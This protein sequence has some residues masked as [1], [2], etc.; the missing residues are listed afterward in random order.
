M[1]R[2]YKI[3]FLATLALLISALVGVSAFAEVSSPA[4]DK[5]GASFDSGEINLTYAVKADAEGTLKLTIWDSYPISDTVPVHETT[6]F[7]E[8]TLGSESYKVFSSDAVLIQNLRKPYY[9][10]VS[11]ISEDG[12][13]ISRSEIVK[14]SVFNY[15]LDNFATGTADQT[16]LF[17][18]LLNIGAAMQKQLLGTSIYPNTELALAGGYANEY[19]ALT[20]N[21]YVDGVLSDSE[22]AYYT[23]PTVVRIEADKVYENAAFVGF[24]GKDGE[25]KEYGELTSSTWNEYPYFVD[26]I[27]IS[28]ISINYSKNSPLP[29]GYDKNN[30]VSGH[31]VTNEAGTNYAEPTKKGVYTDKKGVASTTSVAGS[32]YVALDSKAENKYLG[33]YKVIKALKDTT[34]SDTSLSTSGAYKAGDIIGT[35]ALTVKNCGMYLPASGAAENANVHVFETDIYVYCPSN[36]TPTYVTLV[37]EN[38]DAFWGFN[39][40]TSGD[41]SGFSLSVK[42]GEDAGKSF[43]EGVTLRQREWYN[44][45]VEYSFTETDEVTVKTYIDGK[46]TATFTAEAST[47]AAEGNRDTVFSKV[48]FYHSDNVNNATL[49]LDNTIITSEMAD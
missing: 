4:I 41:G 3:I 32:A 37:N 40:K 28:E 11:V 9:A 10:Q 23:A 19:Y 7:T 45:R 12:T 16:A 26:A 20:K 48:H 31:G 17:T 34:Y 29:V 13:A 46:L 18:R 25:L 22:T 21:V 14:Y 42:D 36:T 15:F 44:L 38:G 39:I 33:F 47:D 30:S 8:M 1:K 43:T 5:I 49:K 2:T 27:G 35:S 24:A 6:E